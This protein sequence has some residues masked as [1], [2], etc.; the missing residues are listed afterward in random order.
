MRTGKQPLCKK[1]RRQEPELLTRR[2]ALCDKSLPG[3]W[4]NVWNKQP[5]KSKSVGKLIIDKK[6]S[7]LYLIFNKY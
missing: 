5:V 3:G 4:L 1:L 2:K 6:L 7:P